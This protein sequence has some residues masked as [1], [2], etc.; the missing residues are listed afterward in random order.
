MRWA[1][2]H[3]QCDPLEPVKLGLAK[4]TCLLEKAPPDHVYAGLVTPFVFG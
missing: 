2:M 1:E 4:G 3:G